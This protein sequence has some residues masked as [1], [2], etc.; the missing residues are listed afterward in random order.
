ML[1]R[2]VT[3]LSSLTAQLIILGQPAQRAL[4]GIDAVNQLIGAVDHLVGIVVQRGIF[5]QL[6]RRSLAVVDLGR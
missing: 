5:E 4:A 2:G 3:V 6:A 1:F